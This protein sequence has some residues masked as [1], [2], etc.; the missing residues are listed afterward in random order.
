MS[1]QNNY[2]IA[3]NYKSRETK[4]WSGWKNSAYWWETADN[5]QDA[6]QECIDDALAAA[7]YTVVAETPSGGGQSGII[8]IEFGPT[9]VWAGVKIKATPQRTDLSAG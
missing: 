9:N 3:W 2:W 5:W 8:E 6:I 7:E 4:E 1:E